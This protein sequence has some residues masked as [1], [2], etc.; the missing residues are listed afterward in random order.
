M[1]FAIIACLVLLVGCS[2][3]QEPEDIS[4]SADSS[5]TSGLDFTAGT[6]RIPVAEA[7]DCVFNPIIKDLRPVR[8][9][10]IYS[11]KYLTGFKVDKDTSTI[12]EFTIKWNTPDHTCNFDRP[13]KLVETMVNER[14]RKLDEMA[15]DER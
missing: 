7:W 1:K 13:Y 11:G 3:Q 5:T 2:E 12:M 15:K 6:A 9:N 14:N 8:P 10:S 4:I